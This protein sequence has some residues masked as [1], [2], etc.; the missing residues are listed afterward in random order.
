MIVDGSIES[1][2]NGCF[3]CSGRTGYTDALQNANIERRR[4]HR[5]RPGPL[6][7][8]LSPSGA[9]TLVDISTTGAL[10]RVEIPV[11]IDTE[12]TLDLDW[13]AT[14]VQLRGRVVRSMRA[15][16]GARTAW[17]DAMAHDVA[18]QFVEVSSDAFAVLHRLTG[19]AR[20][21]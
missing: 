3:D 11:R 6:R 5:S 20:L 17:T 4:A 15:P 7:V 10:V 18:I 1:P 2:D 14:V 16:A 13:E 9:G 8:R 21:A 12:V 19:G